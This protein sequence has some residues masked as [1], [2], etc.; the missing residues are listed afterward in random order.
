MS[1]FPDP[2]QSRSELLC[3]H[4][5]SETG[6]FSS[7]AC[8]FWASTPSEHKLERATVACNLP[9]APEKYQILHTAFFS[10]RSNCKQKLCETSISFVIQHTTGKHSDFTLMGTNYSVWH[11][12]LILIFFYKENSSAEVITDSPFSSTA[13]CPQFFHLAMKN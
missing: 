10:S 2:L 13:G 5:R 1:L 11:E 3:P 12:S 4:S 6:S 7:S 8:T 9:S